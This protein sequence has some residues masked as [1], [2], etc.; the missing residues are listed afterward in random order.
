MQEVNG[1]LAAFADIEACLGEWA[2]KS[3]FSEAAPHHMIR[4]KLVSSQVESTG[5]MEPK[6]QGELQ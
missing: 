3:Q 2:P 5:Q 1:L 6:V 4:S